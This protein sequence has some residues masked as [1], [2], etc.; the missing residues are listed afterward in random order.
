MRSI[1]LSDNI[2]G[3]IDTVALL[4]F[5]IILLFVAVDYFSTLHELKQAV[6]EIEEIEEQ[7]TSDSDTNTL[8]KK[9][10]PND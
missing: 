7:E 3:I 10:A 9:E 8:T 6:K 2:I 1:L 4:M 5:S